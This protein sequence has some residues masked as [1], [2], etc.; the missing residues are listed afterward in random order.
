MLYD[1]VKHNANMWERGDLMKPRF[2][3]IELAE[4]I[5]AQ[6]ISGCYAPG[7][8]LPTESEMISA[9]GMSRQTVRQALALLVSENV[10]EKRQGSGSKVLLSSHRATNSNGGS[11]VAVI[12]TYI[13]EYIFPD[14]L[15][16]IQET[17]MENRYMTTIFAT[18]NR[19][20][21]ERK[22]LTDIMEHSFSGLIVEG[23]KTAFPNPNTDLYK[24]IEKRGIPTVFI[25]SSYQELPSFISVTADDRDGGDIATKYLIENGHE[26][27]AGIFKSDDIQGHRRYAGYV[28]ALREKNL[29]I[30][31][32]NVLWYATES[33]ELVGKAGGSIVKGCS[34]AVCYND[35]IAMQ[36]ITHLTAEGVKVP[37]DV[38]VIS[39]DNST[40]SELCVPRIT[41]CSLQNEKIGILAADKLVNLINGIPQNSV[42]LPWRVE[43][44][45][46]V[47]S[48]A[49][50]KT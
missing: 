10:I 27:I 48:L 50:T 34:A 31:D 38:S 26:K 25:H 30:P 11:T 35:E 21:Y 5:K 4:Q 40:L 33:S 19:A 20:D 47:K 12:T 18:K 32:D 42:V 13:N 6:I 28:K 36:L 43:V 15:R 14:I 3:Y 1:I 17:L 16:L 41:S 9:S 24:E 7:D 23:T 49:A 29:Q 44:K 39:F 37:D 2:K 45:D 22:I 8:K 46:S